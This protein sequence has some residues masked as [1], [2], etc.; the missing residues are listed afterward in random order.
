MNSTQSTS[1]AKPSHEQIS[2][3]AEL[4][5][6]AKGTPSGQDEQIWLEAE[7]QLYDEAKE[8]LSN[9]AASAPPSS[10]S[11]AASNQ[12][13]ISQQAQPRSAEP[14]SVASEK[15][16]GSKA[17]NQSSNWTNNQSSNQKST[18]EPRRK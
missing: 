15:M 2:L 16:S 17:I 8:L 13:P 4:L 18:K 11:G 7:Q 3:R 1:E 5:W 12:P 6:K 14:N 10:T 9:S